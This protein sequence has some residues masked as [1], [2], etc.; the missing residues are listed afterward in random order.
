MRILVLTVT[1]P[2]NGV[3][4]FDVGL[5]NG[6]ARGQNE[7]TVRSQTSMGDIGWIKPKLILVRN[8][9]TLSEATDWKALKRAKTNGAIIGAW[10]SP[11]LPKKLQVT[12]EQQDLHNEELLSHVDLFDFGLT[13]W[14]QEGVDLFFG[15]WTEKYRL[16]IFRVD[17]AADTS[18]YGIAPL[19]G[20][21]SWRLGYIGSNV[22]TK[23]HVRDWLEPVLRRHSHFVCGKNWRD[24]HFDAVEIEPK[25]ER[26]Y[27][28]QT[29]ILPN[30]HLD[31]CWKIPGMA[32]DQ[33][34]FQIPA[35]GGFQIVDNH[36]RIHEFF[37]D[38]EIM[39]VSTAEEFSDAVDHWLPRRKVRARI[40]E[41][42]RKRV[43]ADHTFYARASAL[44]KQVKA[45]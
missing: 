45:L 2:C 30:L 16:P 13:W 40:A 17:P 1:D 29:A 12:D 33:R 34:L 38:D 21:E 7:V 18:V 23:S 10:L 25:D 15:P 27:Y 31:M 6:L 24:R 41:K 22:W 14:G 11:W 20:G 36:P 35:C 8:H 26:K 39:V 5:A 4:Y 19:S 9:K 32:V 28:S 37:E 42:A 44:M 43:L 3:Y